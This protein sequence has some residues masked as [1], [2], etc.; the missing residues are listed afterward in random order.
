MIEDQIKNGILAR[1]SEI[2]PELPL[3]DEQIKQGFT[4][5]AF[6]VLQVN[7]GQTRGVNRRYIRS[8][9]FNVHFFPDPK[10]LT[11]KEDCR[12]IAERLYEAMVYVEVDGQLCRGLDH[13][14]EVIDDVL[15]FFVG[16]TV[17]LMKTADQVP[18]MQQLEQEGYL[19]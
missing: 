18:K 13:R 7:S 14:Y 5:P 17:H 16:F 6:F 15:H 9:L 1:L 19:K 11:K 8:L 12:A 4:E 3:Y 10:S 2:D